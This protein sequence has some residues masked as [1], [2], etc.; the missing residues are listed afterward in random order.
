LSPS[1]LLVLF[2]LSYLKNPLSRSNVKGNNSKGQFARDYFVAA[3]KQASNIREV[4]IDLHVRYVQGN[5]SQCTVCTPVEVSKWVR[6]LPKWVTGFN[7]VTR[8]KFVLP[9]T[10]YYDDHYHVVASATSMMDLVSR[11]IGITAR[12]HG[13]LRMDRPSMIIGDGIIS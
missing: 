10:A 11:K 7:G 2:T 3:L 6:E 13:V 5:H 1:A 12:R 8:L 4:T 9:G